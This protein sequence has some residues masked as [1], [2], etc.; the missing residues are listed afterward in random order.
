MPVFDTTDRKTRAQLDEEERR[1]KAAQ[2][3]FSGPKVLD[4]TDLRPKTPEKIVEK[5]RQGDFRHLG[6][7][8]GAEQAGGAQA[9]SNFDTLF[10]DAGKEVDLDAFFKKADT[11]FPSQ[12]PPPPAPLAAAVSRP[13]E[14]TVIF[15][16]V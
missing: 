5:T 13:F 8:F 3:T 6:G 14:S 16:L 10:P 9:P 11:D 1:R 15:A 2:N 4:T 12:P 7:G